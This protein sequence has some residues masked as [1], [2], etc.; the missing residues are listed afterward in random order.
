LPDA[1][2]EHAEARCGGCGLPLSADSIGP[3][4]QCGSH[5]LQVSDSQSIALRAAQSVEAVVPVA[6]LYYGIAIRGLAEAHEA[7][8]EWD[9]RAASATSILSATACVECYPSELLLLGPKRAHYQAAV[10]FAK[11]QTVVDAKGIE[12]RYA[13]A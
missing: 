9:R 4:P 6:R 11:V 1:T 3:C 5:D 7:A 12:D 2:G 10:D 13:K 8:T